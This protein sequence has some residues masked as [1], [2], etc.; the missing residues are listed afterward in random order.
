MPKGLEAAV[1]T[2]IDAQQKR[3]RLLVEVQP[4]PYLIPFRF[5]V[6]E[7][8]ITFPHGGSITWT[9]KTIEVGDTMQSPEGQ[10]GRISLKFDDVARD[11]AAYVDAYNFAGGTMIIKR[12]YLDGNHHAPTD[13]A[14]YNEVFRGIM[15]TPKNIGVQWVV[16]NA[17]SGKPLNVRALKQ[18]YGKECSHIFGDTQC[19]YNDYAE[20]E[21]TAGQADSGS[22][23]TLVDS[24]LYQA[25]DYWNDGYIYI[26]KGTGIGVGKVTDFAAGV[27][28]FADLGVT[29]DSTCVYRLCKD[30][31]LMQMGAADSGSTTTLTDDG[32]AQV[33][34]FWNYGVI[35]IVKAGTVYRR[36]VKDF[37]AA[38]DTVTFDAALPITVDNTCK[39]FI[40]AGCDKTYDTCKGLN[41]WGPSDDNNANFLGFTY[42]GTSA[43]GIGVAPPRWQ[44]PSNRPRPGGYIP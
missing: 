26:M 39:F 7:S 32:L 35:E 38:S 23:T 21:H 10:I 25:D 3:T 44:D 17:T 9:A 40:R 36:N 34:D 37:D 1:I 13:P 12:I 30:S 16:M 4:R 14:D 28:T 22:D 8:N 11:M 43:G 5:A 19:N 6:S 18:V 2:E 15:E 24:D 31:T 27:V 41:A 29:V 20:L 33:D 42:I